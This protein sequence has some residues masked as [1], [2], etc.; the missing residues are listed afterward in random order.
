MSKSHINDTS[1]FRDIEQLICDM[2]EYIIDC[3]LCNCFNKSFNAIDSD[4]CDFRIAHYNTKPDTDS[5]QYDFGT[6]HYQYY[7]YAAYNA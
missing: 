6:S 4:Q 1:T 5:E 3:C 7:H 2:K